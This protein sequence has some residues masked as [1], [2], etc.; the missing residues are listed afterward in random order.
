MSTIFLPRHPD[1][2]DIVEKVLG[3]AANPSEGDYG[4]LASKNQHGIH[5]FTVLSS[6]DTG[7]PD[8]DDPNLDDIDIVEGVL[9]ED[10][11]YPEVRSA[12]SNVDDPSIPVSTLRSWIIGT[13]WAILIPGLNQF[14][15][16]RYP[17]VTITGLVAQL[18]AFPVG[19]AWARFVPDIKFLGVDLNPGPF[20]IKEHVLVT[21]MASVGYQSAYATDVIAVQ[22]VFY[23]QTPNFIY[24]WLVV[25]STQLIGFSFGGIAKRFLVEPPSMIW[26]ANLVTCALFNTLHSAH[27]A[28]IG[29]RGGISRQRFFLY[30]FIGSFTW[31]FLPGYLFQALS[32]FSWV[33]WIAPDNLKINE[34]FGASV[35]YQSGL[36]MSVLTFDWAQ[37][38]YIGSPLA[39]PWW[40]EANVA[41]AFVLFFW[42]VTPILYVREVQFQTAILYDA[43]FNS[44]GTFYDVRRI[45]NPDL[46]FNQSAYEAYSPIYLSATFAMSYGL[47]FASI[48]ATISRR[49]HNHWMLFYRKQICTQARRSLSEQADIHARLMSHYPQVPE[50][51][52]TAIFVLMFIFGCIA[53][54][55]WE[56]QFPVGYFILALIISFFYTVPIGI[57]QA[58]TNQQVALNVITELIIGYALPGNPI[59]MMLF[60]TWGYMSMSQALN[61]AQDLKLGHYMKIPPRTMFFAQTFATIVAG[62]VQLGV[63]AWMFSNINGMCDRHQPDGFTCVST[64]V[65]G[66]ASIVWGVIGPAR[67]FSKGSTYYGLLFFFPLGLI[68][69]IVHWIAY[70]K[71]P[72]WTRYINFP[73]IFT[74]T[75]LLPPATSINYV[76]WAIVGFVFQYL[77]RRRHF[78]WWTK[79]NYVLSAAMDSGVAVSTLVIFFCLQFPDVGSIG[80]KTIQTWWGNTVNFQICRRR[81]GYSLDMRSKV[82]EKTA[83]GQGRSLLTPPRGGF[84]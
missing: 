56:T 51:W 6:G 57:I 48:T 26:P 71:W 1:S 68:A 69:P 44:N 34:L 40:A 5:Y 19:C 66:T 76:P 62:T 65:F 39:T 33:C 78:S 32:Y 41:F 84:G 80:A 72:T 25:M 3:Q 67:L 7:T 55:V 36:G 17:S 21:V 75:G 74:G 20:S 10:S 45:T 50:W 22:R 27:Y 15:F 31:Y 13:C 14:F 59:S 77:I 64:R 30:A 61:F 47:S 11:P 83:D 8:F 70:L 35:Q 29:T 52:Y 81:R 16:F 54:E 9:E 82:F 24:Q 2:Y 18:L 38:A 60:K 37:I 43:S 28:G 12:V 23:H 42:I 4:I 49:L 58:I 79:Y 46:T 73:L 53:I 63:Q